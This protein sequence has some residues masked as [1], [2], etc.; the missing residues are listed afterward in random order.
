MNCSH[1]RRAIQR[2]QYRPTVDRLKYR[3]TMSTLHRSITTANRDVYSLR[4]HSLASQHSVSVINSIRLLHLST[5]QWC[6][7]VLIVKRIHC[8]RSTA[9][10]WHT[11]ILAA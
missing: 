3:Q 5:L 2:D 7:V 9:V 4:D 1:A 11:V 6:T 8:D 10:S